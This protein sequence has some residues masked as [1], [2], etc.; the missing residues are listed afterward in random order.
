MLSS[1]LLL[2]LR[3]LQPEQLWTWEKPFFMPTGNLPMAAV[4]TASAA[5]SLLPGGAVANAGK[6]GVVGAG[7]KV[8]ISKGVAE[9]A[10]S[11][12]PKQLMKE[13]SKEAGFQAGKRIASEGAKSEPAK[14]L[15]VQQ[16]QNALSCLLRN[17]L[18]KDAIKSAVSTAGVEQ[19]IVTIVS[20]GGK[21]PS[22]AI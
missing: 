13:F 7:L 20:V 18:K 19:A 22:K 3:A 5:V 11:E 15:I 4:C 1:R 12:V 17:G 14:Q 16:T 2:V 8:S 6:A 10:K 9:V 21:I